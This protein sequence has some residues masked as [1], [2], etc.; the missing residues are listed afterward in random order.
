[1]DKDGNCVIKLPL[2]FKNM[3]DITKEYYFSY[4]IYNSDDKN[5]TPPYH[6]KV[7]DKDN[8]K[9]TLQGS[10]LIHFH[11]SIIAYQKETVNSYE[12][13]NIEIENGND[14]IVNKLKSI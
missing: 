14:I 12:K 11:Y 6:L 7:V 2:D 5:E 1:M 9:I 8:N 10:K 13:K 3:R 4:D